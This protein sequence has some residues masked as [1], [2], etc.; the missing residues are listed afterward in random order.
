MTILATLDRLRELGVSVSLNGGKL[1]LRPGSHV[2]ADLVAELQAQKP[3]LVM[4]IVAFYKADRIND[5]LGIADDL[6]RAINRVSWL[7]LDLEDAAVPEDVI[8]PLRVE[9]RRLGELWE[10]RQKEAAA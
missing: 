7:I 3:Y 5:M 10:A 9:E 1:Q 4:A 8:A 2:P 6:V